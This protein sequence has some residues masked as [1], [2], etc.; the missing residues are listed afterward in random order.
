MTD[1]PFTEDGPAGGAPDPVVTARVALLEMINGY[2]VSQI[3]RA[4]ADLRLAD[5]LTDGARTAAEVTGR[6]SSDPAATYR[7]M[8]ACAAIGLL[9]LDRDGRFS[10]TPLGSLLRSEIPGSMRDSAL[11]FTAP[12]HWLPWGRLPDAVR[13]GSTQARAVLSADAFEY[14]AGQPAEERW[15]AAAMASVTGAMASQAARVIGTAGRDLQ[16][17]GPRRPPDRAPVGVT[18]DRFDPGQNSRP[19]GV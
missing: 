19:R 3:V 5:H 6:E 7:L 2:W 13:Q 11:A 1:N 17:P 15:F 8:R 10:V 12:G 14:L 16:E 9:G 4:A 18:V